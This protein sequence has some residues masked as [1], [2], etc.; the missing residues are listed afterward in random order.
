MYSTAVTRK[1]C[2][3]LGKGLTT[4]NLGVPDYTLALE[5]HTRYLKT[6]RDLGLQVDVLE[7]EP[8]Y[9]DAHFVEDTAVVLPEIAVITNPGAPARRGEV[10]SIEYFLTR[11]RMTL[12]I[13]D[14]GYLDGGDVLVIDRNAYVGLTDRTNQEGFNQ[15]N[16]ILEM[17]D[18]NCIPIPVEA[19]LHLKSSVNYLGDNTVILTEDFAGKEPWQDYVQVVVGEN[20]TYAANTL[21]INDHLLTPAGFPETVAKLNQLSKPLIELDM[22]EMEKMDGGLTCLSLRY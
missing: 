6:L 16:D 8:D 18:Y 11:D 10:E 4:S 13:M 14:P 3:A 20:E 22:S 5:Q 9:P 7:A 12:S 1:P 15:F 2:P 17:Y 19:G 21:W